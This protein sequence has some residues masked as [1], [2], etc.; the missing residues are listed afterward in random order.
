LQHGLDREKLIA[1]VLADQAIPADSPIA[2]DLWSYVPAPDAYG[3]D[4]A[5]A[6][7]LL[8]AAGWELGSDGV[9]VKETTP[10]EFSLSTS[11]DPVQLAIANA[12]AQQWNDL[13]VRVTVQASPTSQF[14]QQVLLPRQY[15]AA[16]VLIDLGPD[17]DPYPFWHSTQASGAGRNLAGF[18][19]PE[20]DQLLENARQSTS[21][22]ERA[23]IYRAFQERFASLRPAILLFAP[24]YPYVVTEELHGLSPGLLLTPSA[25]FF[26]VQRWFLDTSS[27]GG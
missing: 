27:D 17:P 25:R 11:D 12:I 3:F 26:G 22:G 4:R 14:V 9:R 21:P 1:D 13:G 5:R 19:D 8:D 10:L 7:S 15:Q 18:A 2:R 23:D 24:T 16:L 6:E 20:V